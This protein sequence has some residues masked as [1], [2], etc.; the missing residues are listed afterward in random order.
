MLKGMVEET[1]TLEKL[2]KYL[3]RKCSKNY[4]AVDEFYIINDTLSLF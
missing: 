3:Q 4:N 2:S 1:T